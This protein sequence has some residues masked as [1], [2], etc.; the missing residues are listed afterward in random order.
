MRVFLSSTAVDLDEH[1]RIADDTLLRQGHQSVVMERFGPLPDAPVDVC[2]R[3]AASADVVVCVVAHRYGYEPE[4]GKGSITR[5]EVEAARRAGKPV[6]AWIID[7]AFG[8]TQ[9]KEQDR[10]MQPEVKADPAKVR[11]VIAAVE[12]LGDFKTWLRKDF[13]TESFTTPDDLGRKIAITLGLVAAQRDAGG[14]ASAPARAPELRII[15]ALQPAPHFSGRTALLNELSVWVDDI[16]SPD[17]LRALVAAGG[18]GKTAVVEQVIRSLQ[19]RWPPPGAGSVLVWSFYEKPEA[20]SFLRECAQ[21]F[22]GEADD[23]PAG[24]RLE[25]LQRGLRDGRP[26]LIVLDGLERVQAEAGSGLVRGEL[27]DHTLKLLLQAIAAG[28]GRTRALVTSRFALTDLRDWEGHGVVQTLLEDLEPA[29]A[30]QALRGW[31]V[32]G[33]DEQLDAVCQQVGQHALSVAVIGSYLAHFEQGRIEAAASL[34]LDEVATDD[35]KAAKLAR[36]LGFYAERLPAEERELLARLSVFPRGITID[37]L[38]ALVDAG[39]Q[40]AGVL[41]HAKPALARL[42][43]RLVERGLVFRYSGAGGTDNWTA[44]PFVRER[45]AALLGCPKE[46]VFN[47]MARHVGR[48]L[49][50]RPQTMPESPDMLDRYEQLIEA[51]RL[52]GREQEAF[53]LFWFGLGAEDHLAKKLGEYERAYRILRTFLPASGDPRDFGS[54]LT[55]SDQ[56]AGL[57]ALAQAA[58]LL[59]RLQEAAALRQVDDARSRQHPDALG[60]CIGLQSTCEVAVSLGRLADARVAATEACHQAEGAGDRTQELNSLANRAMVR[61]QLGDI[62]HALADFSRA[63]ALESWRLLYSTRGQLHARHHLDLGRIKASEIIVLAG[64]EISRRGGWNFEIPGWQA[65]LSRLALARAQDPSPFI[66]DMRTWT[67]RTGDM[68]W[69]IEAHTLSAQAALA[70][71]DLSTAQAEADDGLR[72]ARLCGFGLKLI[73]LLIT[74][75]AIHL[76]RPD[77]QRALAAAREAL[78]LAT[79]PHCGYAWGEADAAHAWGLAFEA[80]GQR[81]QAQRA[82]RQALAVRERIEHPQAEATRTAL[83]RLT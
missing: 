29:A 62:A 75:S 46:A 37:L 25:R 15:H 24:G 17:R 64:L 8:W 76:A 72:Q 52:A 2:E 51:T 73:E 79:A 56:L 1:R 34:R 80:L 65:M 74:Q 61:H 49:D 48:G 44:H 50:V 82:F 39:G 41:S 7:D 16:A 30:R 10:L 57:T 83:A 63:T 71:G 27:V 19:Q 5:R 9:P 20:D 21:L 4:P 23:A 43:T 45:F 60:Y 6:Y 53:D 59:G 67:A 35:P 38:G 22:L 18:T 70:R 11:D 47:V 68:Q 36:V 3:L 78:D 66:A 40:V 13:T 54:G 31:G 14:A 26:H 58:Y 42:L 77:P 69:I 32:L 81:E 12:A 28:L 55:K 33:R